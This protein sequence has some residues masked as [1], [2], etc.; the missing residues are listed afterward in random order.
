MGQ[1]WTRACSIA[2][3]V[4]CSGCALFAPRGMRVQAVRGR[5]TDID[6]KGVELG[7]DVDVENT[8]GQALKAPS[9]RYALDVERKEVVRSARGGRGV[10]L[11]PGR[12]TTLRVPVRVSYKRLWRKRKWLRDRA[13]VRYR[14]R[15]TLAATADGQERRVRFRHGGTLPILHMTRVEDLRFDLPEKPAPEMLLKLL[16]LIH[17]PNAFE[18]TLQKVAYVAKMEGDAVATL[19]AK[20]DLTLGPG[21]RAWLELAARVSATKAMLRFA[22]TQKLKKPDIELTGLFKTPYGTL[23]LRIRRK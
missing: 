7:I 19:T 12:V 3:L 14:V 4:G 21:E 2:L 17:N 6:R 23:K 20:G 9:Y 1:T 15:G 10:E 11:P 18:V 8:T 5:V 16:A 22:M 13:E